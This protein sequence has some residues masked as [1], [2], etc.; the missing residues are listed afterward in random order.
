MTH[1]ITLVASEGNPDI[2]K[3]HIKEM[4]KIIGF[5]NFK[6]EGKPEWLAK[7]RA[8]DLGLAA[9][10][11]S[12]LMSHLREFCAD[13]KIDVFAS[14]VENR[15]KKLLVADMDSTIIEEE[16][17]DELAAYAGLKEE[18]V[19]ITTEA[20]E[21]RLDF[22][23]ALHKRVGLLKDLEAE[24]LQE[25][26]DKMVL[27]PGAETLVTT[28]NKEGAICVLVSGG[29]T[30]FTGAIAERVGFQ[31][32]HG[33]KLEIKDKK[34]TGMVQEPI[35]DKHSKVDFLKQYTQDLGLGENDSIAI[36]DGANDIPM[37]KNA[38]LGVGYHP[39][40]AVADAVQNVIIHGDLTAALYVQGYSKKD[41]IT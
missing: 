28:M 17:L 8:V 23:E 6:W 19:A 34:L 32:H 29:F 35:L 40:P 11:Q 12:A 27:S 25:T 15:Q 20:M 39:K 30:F 41:I 38:G 26:L 36:G 10:P 18:I 1:V 31:H 21:G 33:N 9:R 22:A 2:S 13:D 3:S 37:L 24:K 7:G 5:Y 14:P 4:E 16:T